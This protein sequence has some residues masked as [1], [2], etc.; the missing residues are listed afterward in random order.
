MSEEY[1]FAHEKLEVYQE[2][3]RF[4]AWAAELIEAHTDRRLEPR[5][6]EL[7]TPLL[8]R[9]ASMTSLQWR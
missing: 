9:C 1:Y 2:A 3:I 4:V 5:F 7:P 8:R 6:T